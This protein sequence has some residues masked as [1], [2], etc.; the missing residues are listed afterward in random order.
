MARSRGLAPFFHLRIFLY[1]ILAGCGAGL[2]NPP[3]LAFDER[4]G[5][6]VIGSFRVGGGSDDPAAASDESLLF[7]RAMQDLEAGRV[8]NAQKGF[9]RLIAADPDGEFASRA[10]EQLAAIY[11][12]EFGRGKEDSLRKRKAE[13]VPIGM[14]RLPSSD[15]QWVSPDIEMN[16]IE[17]AGDRVFFSLASAELGTRAR[18]VIAAQAR[19]LRSN[20]SIRP[21]IE[22]YADDVPHNEEQNY[23]LAEARAQAVRQ[24][25]IEEGVESSRLSIAVYGAKNRISV[26]DGANCAAQNR[27]V[28]TALIPFF[29][30]ST[31]AHD[32]RVPS[33]QPVTS[34]APRALAR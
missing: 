2:T 6:T 4:D 8:A 20:P 32:A 19:W 28:V 21:V 3:A 18:A 17:E 25:L 16:F 14:E 5:G 23:A 10:R 33:A 13:R 15:S 11:G 29:G 31:A 27:R 22:G 34:K 12:A 7:D 1:V 24:G 30:K 9:E 26:C